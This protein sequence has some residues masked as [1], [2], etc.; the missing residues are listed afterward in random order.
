M[1]FFWL[2]FKAAVANFFQPMIYIYIIIGKVLAD[3]Y[4]LQISLYFTNYTF[5]LL[6]IKKNIFK[7]TSTLVLANK[8]VV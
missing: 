7:I 1:K 6:K 3:I 2:G 5:A 4:D 8:K